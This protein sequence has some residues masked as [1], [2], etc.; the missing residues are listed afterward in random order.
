MYITV[1][2]PL[3][4]TNQRNYASFVTLTHSLNEFEVI[5]TTQNRKNTFG[6]KV[7][8]IYFKCLCSRG[9]QLSY[10]KFNCRKFSGSILCD[11]FHV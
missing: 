10:S 3:P 4:N 7:N 2:S 5:P 8:L 1:I 9:S 11:S 6:D